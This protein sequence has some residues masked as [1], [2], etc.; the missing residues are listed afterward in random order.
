MLTRFEGLRAR[1]AVL[2]YE[3]WETCWC[4]SGPRLLLL[5]LLLPLRMFLMKFRFLGGWAWGWCGGA[6]GCPWTATGEVT[7]GTFWRLFTEP[8]GLYWWCGCGFW[9]GDA[10]EKRCDWERDT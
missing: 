9:I 4:G 1:P 10:W 3:F 7:S 5:L 8:E 6:I 2:L